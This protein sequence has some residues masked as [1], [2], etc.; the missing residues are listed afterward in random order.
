MKLMSIA[1]RNIRREVA[2]PE[3]NAGKLQSQNAELSAR[4]ARL[5]SELAAFGVDAPK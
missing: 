2:R 3:V 4:L 5:T 1:T